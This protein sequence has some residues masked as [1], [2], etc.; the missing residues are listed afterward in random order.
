MWRFALS[1][2]PSKREK[3]PRPGFPMTFRFATRAPSGRGLSAAFLLTVL[4]A[5]G[6][7]EPLYFTDF[8]EDRFA[9]EGT[10]ARCDQDREASA[11][12]IECANARRAAAAIALREERARR[13]E[14]EQESERKLAELRAEVDRQRQMAL[15]AQAAAEAAA[16]AA[17]EAQWREGRGEAAVGIDGQPL[18]DVPAEA[19]DT[20]PAPIPTLPA[21]TPE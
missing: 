2:V 17:Y 8:M 13:T 16:Q 9:R 1:F 20:A 3:A 7:P 12:D 4:S 19:A 14:L 11:N 21:A 10:L 5:C 18:G 15:E 6:K